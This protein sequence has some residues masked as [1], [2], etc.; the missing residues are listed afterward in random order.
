M[1]RTL[2]SANG[3]YRLIYQSDGSLVLYDD[4][5][6]TAQWTSNTVGTSAGNVHT[7]NDGNLV[8]Y[9]ALTVGPFGTGSVPR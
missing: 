5:D 3:Q 7:Q 6:Q 9:I 1:S 4:V 8:V 2:T